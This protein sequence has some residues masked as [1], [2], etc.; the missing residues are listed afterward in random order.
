MT[1]FSPHPVVHPSQLARASWCTAL[2][3][4]CSLAL[5]ASPAHAQQT[6]PP[7]PPPP[8]PARMIAPL[9]LVPPSSSPPPAPSGAPALAAQRAATLTAIRATASASALPPDSIRF[10]APA[11]R[12]APPAD[13]VALCS[14]GTFIVAPGD[15]TGC[16]SHRGVRVML[17]PRAEPPLK[18]STA[19]AA[20]AAN[21][22]ALAAQHA[23][24]LAPPSNATMQ[25]K[26]GTFLYGKPSDDRCA[27][28][29]GVAA[30]F[31]H[32]TPAPAR[33]ARP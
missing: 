32:P 33:P 22:Q 25:C 15:S 23:E 4:A 6:P 12:I 19:S 20:A 26:D 3:A 14:D 31:S 24:R 21:V 1:N 28:N 13:A 8:P 18:A 29:G 2:A 9:V 17:P 5:I 11:A 30:I 16:A 7:S 10:M 27:G